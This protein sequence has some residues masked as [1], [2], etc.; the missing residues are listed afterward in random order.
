MGLMTKF[1]AVGSTMGPPAEREYPVDPVGV[2]KITPSPAIS[3]R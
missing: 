1:R 2:D 3:A